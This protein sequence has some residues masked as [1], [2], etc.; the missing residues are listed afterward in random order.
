MFHQFAKPCT[1][2][3]LFCLSNLI[4]L[5]IMCWTVPSQTLNLNSVS[6]SSIFLVCSINLFGTS[7]LF[8]FSSPSVISY[9]SGILERRRD[10]WVVSLPSCTWS[11]KLWVEVWLCVLES[12]ITFWN[13]LDFFRQSRHHHF[14]LP[15]YTL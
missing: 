9:F 11:Q 8:Y 1:M 4:C 15:K 5:T 6:E 2:H 13:T 12:L 3:F 14:I 7:V 10:G